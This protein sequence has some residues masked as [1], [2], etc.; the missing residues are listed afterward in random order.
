MRKGQL[1]VLLDR[2]EAEV[3]GAEVKQGV[4]EN[5]GRVRPQ[6]FTL[7][8]GRFFH[9]RL[10]ASCGRGERSPSLST[11]AAPRRQTEGTR[12]TARTE[13]AQDPDQH[14]G[15]LIVDGIEEYVLRAGL[16]EEVLKDGKRER[17]SHSDKCRFISAV[18]WYELAR[19]RAGKS[20][21]KAP[22]QAACTRHA[23]RLAFWM[24]RQRYKSRSAV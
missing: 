4:E 3:L 9:A 6:L 15:E 23:A 11:G 14:L 21:G 18:R 10:N 7:P 16:V 2:G 1:P 17:E 24:S 12:L 20:R 22:A 19:G 8:Q 5:D 13:T